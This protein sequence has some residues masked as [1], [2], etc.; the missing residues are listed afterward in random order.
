MLRETVEGKDECPTKDLLRGWA[1]SAVK[2]VEVVEGAEYCPTE[3]LLR[4]GAGLAGEG[5]EYSLTEDL[6][7]G[8]AEEG[9]GLRLKGEEGG[10]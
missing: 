9:F 5:K 4:R 1:G 8:L 7:R 2:G 3:D 6:L 10:D